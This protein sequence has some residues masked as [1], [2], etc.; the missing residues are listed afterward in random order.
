ATVRQPNENPS[1]WRFGLH[2]FRTFA[3]FDEPGTHSRSVA[4][5]LSRWGERTREP[6]SGQAALGPRKKRTELRHRTAVRCRHTS[7]RRKHRPTLV[8][9]S[10]G[11]DLPKPGSWYAC[12]LRA[13]NELAK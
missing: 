3:F 5:R 10:E 9:E 13:P 8:A 1:H 2:R 7:G 4:A 12:L 6:S 11:P